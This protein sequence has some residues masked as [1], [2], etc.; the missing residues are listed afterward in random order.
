MITYV[1]GDL[2]TS[3]ARVLVNPVNTVGT[4]SAGLAKDFKRYYPAMFTAYK[5]LC[6]R[7]Q[8]DV[9]Q[10]MVYRTAHKWLLNFPIK[11]HYRAN[12]RPEYIEQGLQKFVA[13]YADQGIT[14]V[15]FPQL[16]TGNGGLDWEAEVRPLMEAYLHPLPVSVYVHIHTGGAGDATESKAVPQPTISSY[17]LRSWLHGTPIAESFSTFYEALI[18]ALRRSP[19]LHTL[20]GIYAP[21]AAQAEAPSRGRASLKITPK[22]QDA[23]RIYESLLMDLWHYIRRSG[24]VLPQNLPSGLDEHGAYLVPLLAQLETMQA[25]KLASVAANPVMGLQY[26]PPVQKGQ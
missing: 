21:F 1:Y 15:S 18:T 4:M 2:L 24:Y 3:P 17:A 13:T 6:E 20:D 19:T 22:Q 26:I 8:F 16:G 7:D 9:G 11:K 14:S 10:L 12:S 23:I 5:D 25:V